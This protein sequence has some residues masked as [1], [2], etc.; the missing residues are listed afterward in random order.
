MA[1]TTKSGNKEVANAEG[2]PV[3]AP[4][5]ALDLIMLINSLLAT[6]QAPLPSLRAYAN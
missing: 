5:P 4:M 2:G 1:S 6:P 3:A